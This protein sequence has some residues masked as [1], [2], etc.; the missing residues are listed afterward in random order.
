MSVRVL[1]AAIAAVVAGASCHPF[2]LEGESCANGPCALGLTCVDE[3]C[4][5]V[6]PPPPPPPP[7]ESDDECVLDG[8][9]DG[10]VCNDGVCDYAD[11][12]LDIQCGVRICDGGRCADRHPCFTEDDCDDDQLCSDGVCRTA[13]VLD[14]ECALL[15]GVLQVCVEGECRQRCLGDFLCLGGICEENICR[16]PQCAVDE[17]CGPGDLF[18][19]G[20][21]CVAF[22]PCDEDDDCF[23]PNW[24]CNELGRCE[25]RPLCSIDAECGADRCVDGHCRPAQSCAADSCDTG[26]E[27]V[28]GRC[29][30]QP[31]CRTSADC[32]D[33]DVCGGGRCV[34]APAAVAPDT[35]L[36]ATPHGSCPGAC[37][38]VLLVGETAQ[39]RA[40]GFDDAG[41]PVPGPV[42]VVT[43]MTHV[44]AGTLTTLSADT[45]GDFSVAFGSSTLT[46]HVRARPVGALVLVV[47]DGGSGAPMAGVDV[48]V[49][50]ASA[51][52]TNAD[53][54]A[55]VGVLAPDE[56]TVSA[57][58]ADGRGVALVGALAAAPDRLRLSMAPVIDDAVAA[59]VR[60]TV[61]GTGD[62]LGD[63]GISLALP[64]AASAS[65]ATL[66]ALFGPPFG[67][68]IG[69]PVVGDL[70]V[71]LPAALMLDGT[72][73]VIGFQDV[74]PEAL[75][76][77][78]AGP[79]AL[80]AFEGRYDQQL[81]FTIAFG[82]DATELALDI[83]AQTE[84]M[85]VLALGAGLLEAEALVVDGDADDGVE[86]VDG[87]GDVA[88][89]VPDYAA[90]PAV[91]AS[92]SASPSLRVGVRV[93]PPP[94]G[95]N[96]RAFAVCGVDAGLFLPAG[97]TSLFG[98]EEGSRGEQLLA[99]APSAALEGAPR[100]CAV[101]AVYDGDGLASFAQ[102]SAELAPLVEL[103]ELPAPPLG[104]FV[105]EDVPS[106]G[107]SSVVIPGGAAAD[108]VRARVFDGSTLWD[109][110]GTG[111]DLRLPEAVTP[112]V[113]AETSVFTVDGAAF[114]VFRGPSPPLEQVARS[115]A[116]AR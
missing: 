83:A 19:E 18:C 96:G 91:S 102:T 76:T 103:G 16:D 72:V 97:V 12:L 1:L 81:L 47:I 116:M 46:V 87:D 9:A 115:G 56:D 7:C 22:T 106:V 29:V 30:E 85:D 65:A 58:S 114:D 57:R 33:G 73:P 24:S 98:T 61:N 51:G 34:D 99:L 93:S 49:G 15:G 112:L 110:V 31:V 21:R 109:V 95:A 92:P 63:T 90:F 10:R 36:I 66:E 104:A 71:T 68:F 84:G 17:D 80:L 48:S 35:V 50:T 37:H 64:A 70:P 55:V 107:R 4:A 39:V 101:H 62:E 2:G 108:L 8:T 20:G 14:D 53:G 67:A 6:E 89:L 11:C 42:A 94:D 54:L 88:E 3:V 44:S 105:L 23:D 75:V 25:E 32:D 82:A 13:C 38:L 111:G 5:L 41:L 78:P 100:R 28:A 113:L 43:T 79:G 59:G 77:A 52:A 69:V 45:A 86:D 74:K 60:A 26:F 27:C 40:Q